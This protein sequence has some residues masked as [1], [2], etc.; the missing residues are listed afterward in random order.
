MSCEDCS[1]CEYIKF[2][3]L[4]NAF[5]KGV[6]KG[7]SDA[8]AHICRIHNIDEKEID[9]ETKRFLNRDIS[10]EHRGEA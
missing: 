7:L 4:C 9:D 1:T 3:K 10:K 5:I 8:K 2:S 6:S